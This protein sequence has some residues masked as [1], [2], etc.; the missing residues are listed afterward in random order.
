[1]S[2]RAV[3]ADANSA[4]AIIASRTNFFMGTVSF[5]LLTYVSK[6]STILTVT[7]PV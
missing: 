3:R 5:P 7:I 2:I 4:N 1:M 6:L